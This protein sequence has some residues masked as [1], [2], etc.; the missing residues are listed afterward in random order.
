[1]VRECA[2]LSASIA[3]LLLNVAVMAE[4]KAPVSDLV[5]TRRLEI[6]D[7]A[8]KVRVVIGSGDTRLPEGTFAVVIY[9]RDGARGASLHTKPSGGGVLEIL[10]KNALRVECGV[11]NGNSTVAMWDGEHSF[12][13]LSLWTNEGG[14]CGLVLRDL[15]GKD[16]H[17]LQVPK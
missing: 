1:M 3:L 5:Q 2:L 13:R 12:K 4:S 14:A 17:A 15:E 7:D 8:G 16:V 10:E 9:D 11:G 6:L